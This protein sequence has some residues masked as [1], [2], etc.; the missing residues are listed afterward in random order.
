MLTTSS[1]L[2]KKES[3]LTVEEAWDSLLL[4]AADKVFDGEQKGSLESGKNA[5]FLVVD[6]DGTN[7]AN[8]KIQDVYLKGEKIK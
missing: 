3:V 4:V 1:A 6:F 5:D 7:F 8:A 2:H